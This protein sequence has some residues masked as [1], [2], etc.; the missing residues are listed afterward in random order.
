VGLGKTLEV[1]MVIKEL[2]ARHRADK[3][4]VLCP[5]GLTRQWQREMSE[6]F[7]EHFDILTS[8]QLRQWRST[9][10]A[11]SLLS[12]KYP[13]GYALWPGARCACL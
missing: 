8:C 13:N 7:D 6:K 11:G 1:G 5:A 9:R 3:V 10:P 2:K 12:F 4:L